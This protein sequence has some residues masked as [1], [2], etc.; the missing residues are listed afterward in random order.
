MALNIDNEIAISKGLYR[1]YALERVVHGQPFYEAVN[2]ETDHK[3]NCRALIVSGKRFE[4]SE[5]HRALKSRLGN[6]LVGEF[7]QMPSHSPM[8]SILEAVQ[9]ARKVGANHLIAIGGGSVIDAAKVI[10]FW[11]SNHLELDHDL[12][13]LPGI[14]SVDPTRRPENDME[15]VRITAVP[16]TLSVAEHTYFAGVTDLDA[17]VKII[18]A[19]TLMVPSA[20]VYDPLL[21]MEV[22]LP[23]LLASGI[24][25]LDHAVERLASLQ[26]HPMSDATSIQAIRMLTS[27]LPKVWQDPSNLRQRQECQLAAWL[28]ISGSNT[29]VRVGASHALGH[30]LGAHTNLPH[31]LTSCVVLPSVMR[32]NKSVNADKQK[33]ISDVMGHPE[34][35]AGDCIEWFISGLNLPTRLKDVGVERQELE[36]L[37]EKSLS[38]PL[39]RH[40]PRVVESSKDVLEI[41][42][43]AW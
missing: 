43:M 41:L 34:T 40:N 12:K 32:W 36:I 13:S 16:I 31:G 25:A 24:K 30:A 38:D 26:S 2:A 7:L 8:P 1:Q 39:M 22:S 33:L 11:L 28:S 23:V 6:K 37:A 10:A 5:H 20:V 42:N 19:H 21:T 15:W 4:G 18:V 27:A 35:D 3:K 29:G 9:Y 14:D 17:R